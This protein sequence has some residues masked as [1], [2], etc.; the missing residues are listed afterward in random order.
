MNQ[1]ELIDMAR[2]LVEHMNRNSLAAHHKFLRN[3][4]E[5]DEADYYSIN[6]VSAWTEYESMS[7]SLYIII[8]RD[9]DDAMWYY[10][11]D[12]GECAWIGEDEFK[13]SLKLVKQ[14]SKAA[15][16]SMQ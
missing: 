12:T 7:G 6:D 3:E 16:T 10:M 1:Q 5:E 9:Q 14:T 13:S 4:I 15:W 2:Q 8:G 11:A